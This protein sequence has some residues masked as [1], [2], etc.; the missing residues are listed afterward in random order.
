MKTYDVVVV[1]AGPAGS[2]AACHLARQGFEVLLL[3]RKVFPRHKPCGG[4]LSPKAYRQLDFDISDIVRSRVR[5]T[6]LRGPGRWSLTL[7]SAGMEIW[8]VSRDELDFSLLERASQAGAHVRQGDLVEA[9]L[10]EGRVVRTPREEYGARAL[11]GADGSGSLVARTLGLESPRSPRLR[12]IQVECRL[13]DPR[14]DAILDFAYRGGYAWLFPKGDMFNVGMCTRAHGWDLRPAL[15]AFLR[16]EGLALGSSP[17]YRAGTIPLGG[18]FRPLHR[19]AS[20]LVGDAA[21]LADPILG[22]GIAHAMMSGRLA[23][24]S[25]SSYLKGAAEDLS[26]YTESIRRT[27][28]RDL[29]AL[30]VPAGLLY[31]FPRLFLGAMGVSRNMKAQAINLLTGQKSPSGVWCTTTAPVN[32]QLP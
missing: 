3:D 30:A 23:A 11:V 15:E 6:R 21:G 9:V 25:V 29:R 10:N 1:G 17:A 16:G 26:G 5:R 8:M 2:T 32:E 19:G 14:E 13:G 20:L 18:S 28:H 27:L 31:R 22:E 7:E 24:E 4:A 12:S